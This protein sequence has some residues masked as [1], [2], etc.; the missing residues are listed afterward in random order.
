MKKNK[1]GI[2]IV[3]HRIRTGSA[4]VRLPELRCKN[5]PFHAEASISW[6][7]SH[8]TGTP[9]R[10]GTDSTSSRSIIFRRRASLALQSKLR[11][12]Y[13]KHKIL[14][15]FWFVRKQ[16]IPIL[17]F[18]NNKRFIWHLCTE[19]SVG[20]R[21]SRACCCTK[22]YEG[23]LCSRFADDARFQVMFG[24]ADFAMKEKTPN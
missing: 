19:L 3:A 4:A 24:G 10:S 13:P 14:S 22:K 1:T 11:G 18:I 9:H 21:D 12:D 23:D 17:L 15:I 8:W 16:R 2:G 6:L 20:N 5:R 7:Y